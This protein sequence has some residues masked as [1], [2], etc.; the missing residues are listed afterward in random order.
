MLWL[1][2]RVD[3]GID[4]HFRVRGSHKLNQ[5][6]GDDW[7]LI[8]LAVKSYQLNYGLYDDEALEVFDVLWLEETLE[9]ALKGEDDDH[10]HYEP[11]EPYMI[12]DIYP[13]RKFGN[14]T[15]PFMEWKIIL[16]NGAPSESSITLGI[17]DEEMRLLLLYL[18]YARGAYREGNQ[19]IQKMLKDG[20][21]YGDVMPDTHLEKIAEDK[22]EETLGQRIRAQRIRLGMTQEELAEALYVEKS[23]IS[24][25]ENDKK[26][27]RA[28]GLAEIAKVLQTMPNYLLGFAD[29][30]DGFADEALGLLRDVK[31]QSV[32]EILLKQIRA[33]I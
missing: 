32:R 15:F 6:S 7:C 21:L 1:K 16:W 8:D 5:R 29:N 17:Y 27:M 13:R 26:E 33:L 30:N 4:L 12:F 24:Y 10:I 9:A 2:L 14:K 28:S 20:N 25:Y 11:I 31:D 18:K 22:Q 3:G 19:E 23:I